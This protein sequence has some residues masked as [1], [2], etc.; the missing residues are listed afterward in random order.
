MSGKRENPSSTRAGGRESF[1]CSNGMRAGKL[2]VEVAS[3]LEADKGL[4]TDSV[5]L[6]DLPENK[7]RE[8][9]LKSKMT[10]HDCEM[11]R[12]E[13]IDVEGNHAGSRRLDPLRSTFQ[14]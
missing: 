9:P 8:N 4:E 1:R 5:R 7:K 10:F 11:R 6:F 12:D 13:E 14:P 3:R 2:N